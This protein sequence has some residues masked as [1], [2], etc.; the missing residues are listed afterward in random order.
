MYVSAVLEGAVVSQLLEE[1]K[2]RVR[3]LS[4]ADKWYGVTYKEDK[5]VVVNA[6]ASMREA[7]LYPE[8]LWK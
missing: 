4:S 1:G 5:P 2:A 6:L 3:V 8:K 7:G